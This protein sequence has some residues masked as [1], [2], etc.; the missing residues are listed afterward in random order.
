ME[1]CKICA[2]FDEN[3]KDGTPDRGICRFNPPTVDGHQVV[4]IKGRCGRFQVSLP[5]IKE[6]WE[7]TNNE[8]G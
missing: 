4:N 1:H 6:L 3:P 5:A 2:L 7:K 8:K